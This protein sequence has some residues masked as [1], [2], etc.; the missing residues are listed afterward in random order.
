MYIQTLPESK[1]W[2]W[3]SYLQAV[4]ENPTLCWGSQNISHLP[5]RFTW[6]VIHTTYPK[7]TCGDRNCL[8]YT[9]WTLQLLSTRTRHHNQGLHMFLYIHDKP[10]LRLFLVLIVVVKSLM[11]A[12]SSSCLIMGGSFAQKACQVSMKD[13]YLDGSSLSAQYESIV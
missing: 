11:A 5:L 10:W 13:S 6:P 3:V 7:S 12:P 9:K 4:Q 1:S 8:T 2:F